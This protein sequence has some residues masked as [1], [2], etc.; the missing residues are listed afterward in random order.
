[1]LIPVGM[2]YMTQELMLVTKNK[3]GTSESQSILDVA[4]VPLVAEEDEKDSELEGT[5]GDEG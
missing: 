3:D 2:P 4:F 5:S 1:M